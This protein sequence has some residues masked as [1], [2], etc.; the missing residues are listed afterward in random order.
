MAYGHCAAGH[1]CKEFSMAEDQVFEGVAS[2]N[3]LPYEQALQAMEERTK[4][5]ATTIAGTL[6]LIEKALQPLA[7]LSRMSANQLVTNLAQIATASTS[8]AKAAAQGGA[9][10]GKALNAMSQDSKAWKAELLANNAAAAADFSKLSDIYADRAQ[11]IKSSAN[12]GQV[13]SSG[14]SAVS[15]VGGAKTRNSM[16]LEEYKLT[17]QEAAKAELALALAI[18]TRDAAVIEAA[19]LTAKLSA[20]ARDAA[21]N[22]LRQTEAELKLKENYY[23]VIEKREAELIRIQDQN[24]A[25][26]AQAAGKTNAAVSAAK[27]QQAV[28]LVQAQAR[29]EANAV[30]QSERNKTNLVKSWLAQQVA[31]TKK[32]SSE[33]IEAIREEVNKAIGFYEKQAAEA[34][35]LREAATGKAAG[36]KFAG[37]DAKAKGDSNGASEAEAKYAEWAVKAQT[38]A[39]V[40]K[41]IFDR[42]HAAKVAHLKTEDALARE[43]E[44][45]RVAAANAIANKDTGYMG[46]VRNEMKAVAQSI[47]E[48]EN[49]YN[50]L[51]RA[52]GQIRGFGTQLTFFAGGLAATGMGLK[53]SAEDFDFWSRRVQAS[54]VSAGGALRGEDLS[55]GVRDLTFGLADAV[56]SDD[57]AAVAEGLYVYQSAAGKTI[58]TVEDLKKSQ[59]GLT[60]VF[61]SATITD[62]SFSNTIRGVLQVMAEF[63]LGTED[64]EKTMQILQN[65]TQTT[66]AE[67]PDMF[68]AFKY[69]GPLANKL[70]MEVEDVAAVFGKLSEYGLKGSQAGR[71]FAV[72]LEGLITPTDKT[73]AALQ[74]LLV[75]NQGLAG[76][77]KDIL[78]PGGQFLNLLDKTDAQGNT[79]AGVFRV[80]ADALKGYDPADQMNYLNNIFG[81]NNAFRNAVPLILDQVDALNGV[82]NAAGEGK[83]SIEGMA[84]SFRDTSKQAGLFSAQ[85]DLINNSIRVQFGRE[86]GKLKQ[87]FIVLGTAVAEIMLPMLQSLNRVVNKF[88]DWG[89]ANE[90]TA[91]KLLK[92][93]GIVALIAGAV[94]P[95]L[96]VIGTVV[97]GFG[98]LPV[99][100]ASVSKGLGLFGFSIKALGPALFGLLN[101]FNA[102]GLVLKA[103][104][105]LFGVGLAGS[106]T[107]SPAL[108][109]AF[110]NAF[111]QLG[112]V[113]EKVKEAIS[114]FMGFLTAVFEGDTAKAQASF[115]NFLNKLGPA[116]TATF[117][118]LGGVVK[119][120]APIL[121]DALGQVVVAVVQAAPEL[122]KQILYALASALAPEFV[123]LNPSMKTWGWNLVA[124]LAQ[125]MW[126]GAVR[127]VGQ[128]T[129]WI[130]EQIARPFRSY[131]PPKYGPLKDIFLWGRNLIGSFL[132]GAT[133]AD[134]SAIYDVADRIGSAMESAFGEGWAT[135]SYVDGIKKA[136][137]L[138]ASM[139]EIVREG[140]SVG[141]TYF[142]G[143]QNY[144][145]E[146]FEQIKNISLK[147]QEL[148]GLERALRL[149]QSR[150]ELLKEQREVLQTQLDLRL[151]GFETAVDPTG[152]AYYKGHEQDMVDPTTAA[153]KS[154]IESMRQ[155]LSKEDFQ[156]WISFQKLLWESR[157]KEEDAV[158]KVQ[159]D[160]ISLQVKA[161]EQQLKIIKEQYDTMVAL[162]E[163]A[164]KLNGIGKD[165][166]AGSGGSGGGGS[167]LDDGADSEDLRRA[168]EKARAIAGED[169]SL[170]D[171]KQLGDERGGPIGGIGGADEQRDRE[172]ARVK[173]LDAENRRLKA[174]YDTRKINAKGNA[175]ELA[176]VAK[177][178]EAWN[179]AYQEEKSRLQER[180][181]YTDDVLDATQEIADA[182]EP[183][184]VAAKRAEYA[185]EIAASVGEQPEHIQTANELKEA[186]GD[187]DAASVESQKQLRV[188]ER[189]LGDLRQ[190]NDAKRLEF[191]EKILAAAGD[192]AKIRM[193]K[194][195]QAAWDLAYKKAVEAQ[196]ARTA[197]ARQADQDINDAQAAE[198]NKGGSA[199]GAGAGGGKSEL[200]GPPSAGAG[201][202]EPVDFV[203][204]EQRD[205]PTAGNPVPVE[206]VALP[207][208]PGKEKGLVGEPPMSE[209]ERLKIEDDRAT[210]SQNSQEGGALTG[211]PGEFYDE[212]LLGLEALAST[213]AGFLP[214]VDSTIE[215]IN[216][217]NDLL[218]KGESIRNADGS[219]KTK[220]TSFAEDM[221]D[222]W[223]K[224]D[225][226]GKGVA[227]TL[228][229]NLKDGETTGPGGGGGGA[230]GD[231][232]AA[233]SGKKQGPD[234]AVWERNL[235]K[236]NELGD[237]VNATF[238]AKL[239][240]SDGPFA[241][242]DFML[243]QVNGV[244]QKVLRDSDG[245]PTNVSAKALDLLNSTFYE[246]FTG[247][248]SPNKTVDE[249][250]T[251]MGVAAYVAMTGASSPPKTIAAMVRSMGDESYKLL[252]GEKNPPKT[253]MELQSKIGESMY[254][255]ITGEK[256][257]AKTS[258]AFVD[259]MA[260]VFKELGIEGPIP[261]KVSDAMAKIS[262]AVLLKLSPDGTMPK[263]LEEAMNLMGEDFFKKFSPTGEL[264]KTMEEAMGIIGLA[265][266]NGFTG[267]TGLT[268]ITAGAVNAIKTIFG[269]LAE[270]EGSP[271]ESA[272]TM[273]DRVKLAHRN[274]LLEDGGVADI[275]DTATQQIK[276]FHTALAT[277]EGGIVPTTAAMVSETLLSAK[278]LRD[279]DSSVTAIVADMAL[280]VGEAFGAVGD[281][282]TTIFGF[283]GVVATKFREAQAAAE[284][285]ARAISAALLAGNQATGTE[286]GGGGHYAGID[287]VP[288]GETQPYR[289]T[290]HG[291]EAVLNKGDA[292][293]YRGLK[294]Q[295]LWEALKGAARGSQAAAAAVKPSFEPAS[296]RSSAPAET[297]GNKSTQDGG[298]YSSK[299]VNNQFNIG[300][301]DTRSADEGRNF[302]RQVSLKSAL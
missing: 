281:G 202:P 135:G 95:L 84:N 198:R 38:A 266:T 245:S 172:A 207:E 221:G 60:A 26:T 89:E 234:D 213:I 61:Q 166:A 146:W 214:G 229:P 97:Q 128:V 272:T 199:G 175:E 109:A 236:L 96:I 47:K 62:D 292:A 290:L 25:K 251:N 78:Q 144:L 187:L 297:A 50:G 191:E 282:A 261:G 220:E 88:M 173:A 184:R 302:L 255:L 3:I 276:D 241:T 212:A 6:G 279:G 118:M 133:S 114:A 301:I 10:V 115:Q 147:Y 81:Q 183:E 12:L 260:L 210:A 174:E 71:G 287:T 252:T 161:Q 165:G 44:R 296:T 7:S 265:A 240:G 23:N 72:M 300:K 75:D 285:A 117:S 247:D 152:P 4:T 150:L 13:Q 228:F 41:Q 129:T 16:A 263:N 156:S 105:Y 190:T 127:L 8:T 278:Q 93:V 98:T 42:L 158:L 29:S 254:E 92:F 31:A 200:P 242:S 155:S 80:L 226:W 68:Q 160:A 286:N 67:L 154:R 171:E 201:M 138:T 130:A 32:A 49:Q 237:N 137:E 79:T 273:A 295:G 55:K 258:K 185:A 145:G 121:L 143:L 99:V 11:K 163:Y 59:A 217:R 64:M 197:A 176:K 299:T 215:Q 28:A 2:L 244:W 170:K 256:A 168:R 70:G 52:G 21:Q 262:D 264:P 48:V 227:E 104:I 22:N 65:T 101:P 33:K 27:S 136:H 132:D 194:E 126:D 167:E 203:P 125:G 82:K 298:S 223:S 58:N 204:P 249:A 54:V 253:F 123:R 270:G 164:V 107:R 283:N 140:G 195:E 243:G 14:L 149:E 193:I 235:A 36:F 69:V 232:T 9:D 277:G 76:S 102:V 20:Q 186:G 274:A 179:A 111:A 246:K 206:V 289:T 291:T 56:G 182:T 39:N 169:Q 106:L 87:Q 288:G 192:E 230:W 257:P 219:V 238:L 157:H 134:V 120:V 131:S 222:F 112:P 271:P 57:L 189:T 209:Y 110:K 188:E 51:I 5:A 34:K 90:A 35:K 53:N 267:E 293:T 116:L 46:K 284:A 1:A 94:G 100:L 108:I 15:E 233:D 30:E 208:G 269:G 83:L 153:G 225:G 177:E 85:W 43:V 275:N 73:D 40:E 268:G 91:K 24:A 139:L 280:K 124:S 122:A 103:L 119:T 37:E 248:S 141:A 205:L 19:G 231:P 196:E 74:K 162:Y 18:E 218:A 181:G 250:L 180:K 113:V 17:A 142:D 159:E 224:M 63:Q 148:Y 239:N 66:Q 151:A 294:Q 77:W 178:E 216:Y 211:A 45:V 259:K 86:L